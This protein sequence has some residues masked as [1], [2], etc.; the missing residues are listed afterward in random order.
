MNVEYFAHD[1]TLYV[2]GA[3]AN[4]HNPFPQTVRELDV[5][6]DGVE[7]SGEMTVGQTSHRCIMEIS[8]R[9]ITLFASP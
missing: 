2:D 8:S 1:S 4:G 9:P 5:F 6:D 3:I 7:M